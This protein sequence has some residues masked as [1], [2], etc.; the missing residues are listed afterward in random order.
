LNANTPSNDLHLRHSSV[1][2]LREAAED[3]SD[4]KTVRDS[5]VLKLPRG[6]TARRN[7]IIDEYQY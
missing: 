3:D 5:V 1:D 2:G 6:H 7:T 4:F